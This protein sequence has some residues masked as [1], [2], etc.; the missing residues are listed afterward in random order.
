MDRARLCQHFAGEEPY[1]AARRAE[2]E[3]AFTE[4][5]CAA[6]AGDAAALRA[7]YRG[8]PAALQAIEAGAALADGL[9][10]RVK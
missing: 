5:G 10:E 6:L 2:I 1:D 8:Q 9:L 4:Q 7:R 3:Q